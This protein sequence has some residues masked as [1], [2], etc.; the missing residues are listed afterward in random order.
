MVDTDRRTL[1]RRVRRRGAHAEQ[2]T[3]G[4]ALQPDEEPARLADAG[5]LL[6]HLVV[7]TAV[8]GQPALRGLGP[9][10]PATAPAP[11]PDPARRPPSGSGSA[12]PGRHRR[13]PRHR[14]NPGIQPYV[15]ARGRH[16]QNRWSRHRAWSALPTAP[17]LGPATPPRPAASPPR[18]TVTTLAL[19]ARATV[20]DPAPSR[21]TRG[22]GRRRSRLDHPV[23]PACAP[24]WSPTPITP[25]LQTAASRA[26]ST[27]AR[28]A[29][30]GLV[31]RV[32]SAIRPFSRR[33]ARYRNQLAEVL[34]APTRFGK[35][36]L[37]GGATNISARPSVIRSQP[38]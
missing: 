22:V 30:S 16:Q 10:P 36:G 38:P 19:D 14:C 8:A 6:G 17:R 35:G 11:G 13:R 28:H 9:P 20:T 33:T 26:R 23:V 29:A 7:R 4:L 31:V 25:A 15:V 34:K 3:H 37:T 27:A 21:G 24:R 5:G 32:L 12:R 1:R 2:H 18:R